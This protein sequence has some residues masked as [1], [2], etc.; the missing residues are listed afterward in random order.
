MSIEDANCYLQRY[1]DLIN[2]R[3]GKP[4]KDRKKIPEWAAKTN[5][6]TVDFARRHFDTWG[7][8][9]GRHRYCA[10]RL[11]EIQAQCYLQNY[12]DLQK[13][14]GSNWDLARQHWYEL[15]FKQGRNYNCQSVQKKQKDIFVPERV[16]IENE[17][18]KFRCHGDIHYARYSAKPQIKPEGGP[19]DW[20]A[21]KNF[22]F[23][24]IRS[25][26][27]QDYTCNN[28]NFNSRNYGFKKQCFCELRQKDKPKFCAKEGQ[29][30]K[31]CNGQVIFGRAFDN[32]TT[33][34][35]H[36][37]LTIDQMLNFPVFNFT[38]TSPDS[39]VTCQA[40]T[41][42]AYARPGPEKITH[43]CFCDDVNYVSFANIFQSLPQNI[44]NQ[45][46][47]ITT[48][49]EQQIEETVVTQ[50]ET[51]I[52]ENVSFEQTQQ[53]LTDTMVLNKMEW[54]QSNLTD[55]KITTEENIEMGKFEVESNEFIAKLNNTFIEENI[56]N[57]NQ[58]NRVKSK[59]LQIKK[60]ELQAEKMLFTAKQEI[61]KNTD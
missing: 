11:T 2:A 54:Q 5:E 38:S 8:F 19:D 58:V 3:L 48:F 44:T 57:T 52:E 34:G 13:K 40:S 42:R 6:L 20:E 35:K 21:V 25:D 47:T 37:R 4:P 49:E 32:K 43:Q 41:F 12:P 29:Q 59:L 26:G 9:E 15:G 31:K 30:C 45:T 22:G 10:D 18:G 56:F 16:K 33:E 1:P 46:Y 23:N 27:S 50:Q 53:N 61:E 14:Y 36:R 24:T 7:Y 39:A 17:E 55:T 51:I 60:K 28:E